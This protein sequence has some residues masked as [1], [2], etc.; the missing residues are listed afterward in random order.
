[1]TRQ[2]VRATLP[3]NSYLIRGIKQGRVISEDTILFSLGAQNV[4]RSLHRKPE[5]AEATKYQVMNAAAP[6]VAKGLASAS[7]RANVSDGVFWMRGSSLDQAFNVAGGPCAGLHLVELA[8][9]SSQLQLAVSILFNI[10]KEDW[11][12][13]E[14]M[15]KMRESEQETYRYPD[16]QQ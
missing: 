3:P 5:S 4:V 10:V 13:S 7:G 1:V 6:T 16:A 9:S 2:G 11:Q 12:A 14:E 15:E 8:K